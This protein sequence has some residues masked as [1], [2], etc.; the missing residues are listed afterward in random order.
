[1]PDGRLIDLQRSEVDKKRFHRAIAVIL[2]DHMQ[3]VADE[4]SIINVMSETGIIRYEAKGRLHLATMPTPQQRQRI[5][6]MMKYSV[7][8]FCVMVSHRCGAT[9]AERCFH[10]PSAHEL[11]MFYSSALNTDYSAHVRDEFTLRDDTT[12]WSIVFRPAKQVVGR[13]CKN[14][15]YYY[16]DANYVKFCDLFEGFLVNMNRASNQSLVEDVLFYSNR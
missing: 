14:S 16:I 6:S 3:S 13:V 11:L 8:P 4:V 7:N 10:S 9:L 5:F 12:H 2:P 1:M 15:R